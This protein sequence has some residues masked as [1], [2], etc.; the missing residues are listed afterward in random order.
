M[1]LALAG[2]VLLAAPVAPQEA[3]SLFDG[4]TLE[5]WTVSNF[6]P[7]GDVAV[8]EGVIRL[9][10]GQPLTGIT[11]AG[12]FPVSDYEV[13]VEARRLS[14]SD[15]FATITFPVGKEVCSLV[16]GGWGGRVVGLSSLEGADASENE[17]SRWMSFENG[18]WYSIRLRVTDD[19]ISAWIDD[20]PVV[21]LDH[22]GRLL[23]TRIEVLPSRPFG[24]AAWNTAAEIRRID[25]TPLQPV[26]APP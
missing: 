24:I 2:I 5:G 11:F 9:A 22:R 16:V 18:R 3:H 19:R 12:S 23:D 17:T 15:F 6:H 14:G 13:V 26:P 21:D 7:A 8:R 20:V 10:V 1:L 25:L 4:R